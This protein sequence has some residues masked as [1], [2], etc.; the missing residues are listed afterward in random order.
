MNH[1][2]TELNALLSVI[3]GHFAQRRDGL[4]AVA[5]L[6]NRFEH[7]FKWEAVVALHHALLIDPQPW[8]SCVGVERDTVDLFVGNEAWDFDYQRQ[9]YLW[10]AASRFD[11]W[12]EFKAR[13]TLDKGASELA[14]ALEKD[15]IKLRSLVREGRALVVA[16]ILQHPGGTKVAELLGRLEQRL[17][18]PSFRRTIR[19]RSTNESSHPQDSWLKVTPTPLA[20]IVAWDAR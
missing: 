6:G 18:E 14:L 5:Q 11:V 8:F 7:W 20:I 3:A 19:D 12:V 17:G 13:T 1:R 2:D 15:R 4:N 16:L 10:P 9:E